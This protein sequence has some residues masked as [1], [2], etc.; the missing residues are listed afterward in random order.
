MKTSQKTPTKR[1]Q[2]EIGQNMKNKRINKHKI[3][4]GDKPR[5][6]LPILYHN[7]KKP[8]SPTQ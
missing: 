7:S 3:L 4:E 8:N 6:R 5:S 2:R 1:L